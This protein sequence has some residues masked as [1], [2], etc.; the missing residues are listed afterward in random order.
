MMQQ[1]RRWLLSLTRRRG[2]AAAL[3]PFFVC[4]NCKKTSLQFKGKCPGCGEFNTFKE[5]LPSAP[6]SAT[7]KM[8]EREKQR[9]VLPT[10]QNFINVAT[11]S[12]AT[13]TEFVNAL[14]VSNSSEPD[15]LIF[16]DPELTRVFGGGLVMGS[17][18]LLSVS[19]F[20]FILPY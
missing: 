7:S 6:V 11:T 4:D 3:K 8:I 14:N 15:R 12:V 17:V 20:L 5:K 18:V 10:E 13:S 19:V 2:Y 9:W 1:H 16:D